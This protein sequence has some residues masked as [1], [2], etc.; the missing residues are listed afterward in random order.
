M[1]KRIMI[2][3]QECLKPIVCNLSQSKKRKYCGYKC[4]AKMSSRVLNKK[5]DGM[6]FGRWTVIRQVENS[7]KGSTRCLCRCACGTEKIVFK[8][9]LMGGVSKSCGCWHK[10]VSAK[11][12][13]KVFSKPIPKGTRF[14]RLVVIRANGCKGGS[15][16]YLCQCDCGRKAT[17]RSAYL[18][19]GNTKSCGCWNIDQ[20]KKRKTTHGLCGKPGY[21]AWRAQRRSNFDKDLW[22]SDMYYLLVKIQPACIICGST[23]RLSV[24]HVK[25]SSQGHPLKPGNAITLCRSCN[26]R[27]S[28]LPLSHLPDGWKEK[29][30]RAAKQFKDA[31]NKNKR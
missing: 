14:H 4:R 15:I 20:I 3:C 2:E 7:D 31:W 8:T 22:T 25:P 27:K 6:T 10:E 17:I 23:R 11:H 18:R 5:I 28:S 24:D 16:T 1:S 9:G 12:A 19:S 29:I 26:S 30:T 21:E 13:S